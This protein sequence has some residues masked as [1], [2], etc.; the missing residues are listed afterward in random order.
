MNDRSIA[1]TGMACVFPG[2]KSLDEFWQNI[3]DGVD[4]VTEIPPG[5]LNF[6]EHFPIADD[7][8]AYVPCRRGGFLPA[9]LR[10]DPRRFGI[11]PNIVVN[12]E[13]G[14]GSG[15]GTPSV[16]MI[17]RSALSVCSTKSSMSMLWWFEIVRLRSSS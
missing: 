11:M 10:F 5:R 8:E 15:N 1:I 16:I 4:C 2:A 3:V 6:A 14:G 13:D 7:D 9:D 12:G 17:F